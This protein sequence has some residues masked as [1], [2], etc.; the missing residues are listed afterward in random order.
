MRPNQGWFDAVPL[1]PTG[2]GCLQG[3]LVNQMQ[4]DQCTDLAVF[5]LES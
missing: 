1:H 4:A 3:P 5:L 2:Q